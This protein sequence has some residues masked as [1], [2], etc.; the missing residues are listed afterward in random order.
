ML[1]AETLLHRKGTFLTL[2]CDC[3]RRANVPPRKLGEVKEAGSRGELRLAEFGLARS[4]YLAV[5]EL[6]LQRMDYF[7]T[8]DLSSNCLDSPLLEPVL[9]SARGLTHLLLKN[10]RLSCLNSIFPHCSGLK[11]L[12][13]RQNLLSDTSMA[14]LL[15]GLT[16]HS[17]E[18]AVL[19]LSLNNHSG[20]SAFLT[21]LKEF[22]CFD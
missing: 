15:A 7:H 6:L 13:L 4:Q 3:L 22:L 20:G 19:D 8:V 2:F 1:E 18:L 10:N 11:V 17:V 16:A 5:V 21:P 12:N 9:A 14:D